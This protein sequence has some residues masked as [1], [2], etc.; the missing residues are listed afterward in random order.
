MGFTVAGVATGKR[1]PGVG[2]AGIPAFQ[3]V[4][5]F[6][7]LKSLSTSYLKHA[8][9]SAQTRGGEG[10]RVLCQHFLF[11]VWLEWMHRW[12]LELKPVA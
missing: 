4:S 12:E 8:D 9:K 11:P 1:G 2:Q 6:S 5:T 10:G 3:S 7:V